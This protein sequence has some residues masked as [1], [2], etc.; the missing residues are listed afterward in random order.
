[1]RQEMGTAASD[2]GPRK[3]DN[4]SK[5]S[6]KDQSIMQALSAKDKVQNAELNKQ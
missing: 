5:M 2:K 3:L 1:M 4:A 6:Y